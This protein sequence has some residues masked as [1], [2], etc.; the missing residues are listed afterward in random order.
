MS[1]VSVNS[2]I[3]K[4]SQEPKKRQDNPQQT[5]PGHNSDQPVPHTPRHPPH[6]SV[7]P[8]QLPPLAHSIQQ[9][10]SMG[11]IHQMPSQ[12]TT[13]SLTSPI[14]TA[15]KSS[16]TAPE[17]SNI[18]GPPLGESSSSTNPILS[19]L[20]PN[21][22]SFP[23]SEQAFIEAMKLRA[24]QERTKQDYYRVETANKNLAI[25]QTALKAQIPTHLIPLM[26]I[27]QMPELPEEQAQIMAQNFPQLR[28]QQP[29]YASYPQQAYPGQKRSLSQTGYP[30]PVTTPTQY[31]K[32]QRSSS[33]SGIIQ[34]DTYNASPIPPMSYRFGSGNSAPASSFTRR[35]LSPAKIGAAA[36]A[37]LATPTSP[38]RGYASNA[39]PP[40]TSSSAAAAARRSQLRGHGHQ[41]HYSMPV[42]SPSLGP[43]D[44]PSLPPTH[45][46]T[47][48]QSSIDLGVIESHS[49][50]H[51]TANQSPMSG[52]ASTIQVKPIPAQPLHK[53]SKSTQPP[54]QESM[55]SFQHIIQFHHWKPQGPQVSSGIARGVNPQGSHKRHKSVTGASE[56]REQGSL[57]PPPEIEQSSSI[58]SIPEISTASTVAESVKT[59]LEDVDPDSSMDT[60][61][62]EDSE[63]KIIPEDVNPPSSALGHSRQQSN[64]GRYPHDI[65][66]PNK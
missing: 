57:L 40:S 64:V 32:P 54:S 59:R 55:T 66:S 10:S 63:L 3:E 20:G 56:E 19:L 65:L 11:A 33:T 24:E 12:T 30:D 43:G 15:M 49:R 34:S 62:H 41:R 27:G 52:G 1:S 60:T 61:V 37:N 21:I 50:K 45:G 47:G 2:L 38:Y 36:V 44:T 42:D 35:P 8:S 51:S 13:L 48:S 14:S 39:F 16:S 22:S 31:N 17:S 5:K 18:Q 6:H 46:R 9:S 7:Y 26:C 4:S 25:V 53:Q 29:Q 28:Q 23:Y 58:N